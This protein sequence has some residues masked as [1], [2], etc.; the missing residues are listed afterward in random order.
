MH[1]ITGPEYSSPT[2]EQLELLQRQVDS[3]DDVI[4]EQPNIVKA[5][6]EG[7][8][9]Y[10]S[11]IPAVER[12]EAGIRSG[13]L[14]LLNG[15]AVV[16]LVDSKGALLAS[17][18]LEERL[19]SAVDTT[20]PVLFGGRA[21]IRGRLVTEM[22]AYIDTEIG[23]NV[24]IGNGSV[25][26]TYSM[27]GPEA[28][29]H[30]TES[31]HVG[32]NV[33]INR[34]THIRG[35]TF[36]GNNTTI[37]SVVLIEDSRIGNNTTIGDRTYLSEATIGDRVTIEGWSRIAT[38][39]VGYGDYREGAAMVKD[40]AVVAED[41]VVFGVVDPGEHLKAESIRLPSYDFSIPTYAP[42]QMT[43]RFK[44]QLRDELGL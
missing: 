4:I 15:L 1:I 25:V 29:Q 12:I 17:S 10:E 26:E 31:C 24:F 33:V 13:R 9:L 44:Q 2:N 5:W 35:D 32:D 6:P 18:E 16:S 14:G 38:L 3:F 40:D 42:S 30:G 8:E 27:F 41:C 37:G 28:Y 23:D 36:I 20:G 39:E 43:E 11:K 34:F 22:S 7:H 19:G 21:K